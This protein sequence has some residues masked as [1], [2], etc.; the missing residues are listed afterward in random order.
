MEL[1]KRVS[2]TQYTFL[3][4]FMLYKRMVRVGSLIR[5]SSNSR[6]TFFFPFDALLCTS[7][8]EGKGKIVSVRTRKA[9]RRLELQLQAFFTSAFRWR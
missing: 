2:Y 9:Y 5:T 3:V 8:C 6:I 7:R 4:S 1:T